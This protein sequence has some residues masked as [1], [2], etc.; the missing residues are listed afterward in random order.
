MKLSDVIK[1]WESQLLI[2]KPDD[3]EEV[4]EAKNDLKDY[5]RFK[6][7]LEQEYLDDLDDLKNCKENEKDSILKELNVLKYAIAINNTLIESAETRIKR[8]LSR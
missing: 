7:E 3:T 6:K 5:L 8:A 4:A 1:R 2:I